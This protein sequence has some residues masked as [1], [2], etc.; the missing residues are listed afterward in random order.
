MIIQWLSLTFIIL[1]CQS[2][3]LLDQIVSFLAYGEIYYS[4]AEISG[5]IIIFGKKFLLRSLKI[6]IF[7]SIFS[8]GLQILS[9]KTVLDYFLDLY[10]MFLLQNEEICFV[11]HPT[12]KSENYLKNLTQ[13]D[14]SILVPLNE[15]EL[16]KE[17]AK[18]DNVNLN[19]FDI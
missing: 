2:L 17:Y 8:I 1:I 3:Y 15:E 18:S 14:S 11:K 19:S 7:F 6:L 4:A 10:K 16:R 9:F 12:L 5:L 13:N